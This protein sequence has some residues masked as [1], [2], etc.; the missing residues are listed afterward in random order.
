MQLPDLKIVSTNPRDDQF[1]FGLRKLF[2]EF[3]L[4][5]HVT[6]RCQANAR[7][8]D[9]DDALALREQ[10]VD[11]GRSGRDEGCLQGAQELR[12]ELLC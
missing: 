4:Q 1:E 12:R 6:F 2:L 10:G 11:D 9:V 5:E 3:V 8:E 7:T